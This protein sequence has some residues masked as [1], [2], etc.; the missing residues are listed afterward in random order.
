MNQSD[1]AEITLQV[2]DPKVISGINKYVVYTVKGMDKNGQFDV[3]RRFSDFKTIRQF[4]LT[5]WPG[6]YIPPVPPRKAF[7]NMEQQFIDERRLML[8]DFLKK[9]AT[10]KYLWY[11]EEFQIFL[12]TPGEI[13]K[14]LLSIPKITN[15]EIINKYQETF[16][17]LSGR[18]INR[19]IIQKINDFKAFIKKVQP[20]VQNFKQIAKN[21]AEA[22]Q[23]YQIFL[24]DFIIRVIPQYE[25]N[26]LLENAEQKEKLLFANIIQNEEVKGLIDQYC[27]LLKDPKLYQLYQEVRKE[28]KQLKAFLETFSEREKYELQKSNA[29]QRQKELELELQEVLAGK[30]TIRTLFNKGKKEENIIK[31]QQQIVDVGKEIESYQFICDILTVLVGYVEIDKF[32]VEKQYQYYSMIKN[33]ISYQIHLSEIEEKVWSKVLESEYMQQ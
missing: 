30:T 18:E 25:N 33:I 32:K 1:E 9:I 7:G 21:I 12:K 28:G 15:D 27:D 3:Q 6:C 31:L 8:E 17:E 23:S 20:M 14:A 10:L 24:I 26:V 5:K 29:E 2:C 11:S 16:S 13:E 22:K 19:E 4:L